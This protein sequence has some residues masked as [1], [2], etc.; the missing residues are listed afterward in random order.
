M[1]RPESQARPKRKRASHGYWRRFV[2]QIFH[3][4]SP[5]YILVK[6]IRRQFVRPASFP[7]PNSLSFPG[8]AGR[9]KRPFKTEQNIFHREYEFFALVPF[10]FVDALDFVRENTNLFRQ[11]FDAPLQSFNVVAVFLNVFR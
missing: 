6:S 9:W 4:H 2:A 10:A 1:N 11:F 5:L 8:F 3:F 7:N